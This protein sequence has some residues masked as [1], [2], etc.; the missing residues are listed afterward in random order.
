MIIYY[1]SS[2]HLCSLPCYDIGIS[3][4]LLKVSP[5]YLVSSVLKRKLTEIKR[6]FASS[7]Q[8]VYVII[9]TCQSGTIETVFISVG[10]SQMSPLQKET[11]HRIFCDFFPNF[12]LV[13]HFSRSFMFYVWIQNS[14]S[15]ETFVKL[16]D[17]NTR[18]FLTHWP[19]FLV[20]L[21]SLVLPEM[22]SCPVFHQASQLSPEILLGLHIW[23]SCH[24]HS[25]P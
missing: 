9:V 8:K 4:F 1:E 10:S 23:R 24:P 12:T 15:L 19:H 17:R 21:C 16:A 3:T 25:N 2:G 5:K 11:E 20:K 14:E 6:M 13:Q 7:A 18:T 22:L